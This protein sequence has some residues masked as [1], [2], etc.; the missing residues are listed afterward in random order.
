MDSD[1]KIE[2]YRAYQGHRFLL[3]M[4][5][6]EQEE[7]IKIAMNDQQAARDCAVTFLIG[8]HHWTLDAASSY[9]KELLERIIYALEDAP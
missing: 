5:N 3:Y 9:V 6:P 4:M 2:V 7:P 1:L 8:R